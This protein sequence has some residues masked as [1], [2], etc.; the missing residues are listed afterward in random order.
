[1][2]SHLRAHLQ[3]WITD[4]TTYEQLK[5][6]VMELEALATKWDSSNSLSLPTRLGMDEAVPMEVDYIRGDKGKKGGKSKSKEKGKSKGKEKGK[7]KSEG[8]GQWKGGDKGKT[9]WEKGGS[10][11]KGKSQEKGKSGKAAG[12]CHNCGKPGHYAKDCWSSKRVAPVEGASGGASSSGGQQGTPTVTTTSSVKMVRLLTPPD[13]HSLEIFDLTEGGSGSDDIGH[14]WRVGMIRKAYESEDETEGCW[15]EFEE[16]IEP[17]VDIPEG[18]SI[19]AMDLQDETE[20]QLVQMVRMDQNDIEECL[21]TLDSG[22]ER[23]TMGA[24]HSL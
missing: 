17:V 4:T 23:G 10:G 1:M 19:V 18:V 3:L 20:E 9:L 22:A 14:P 2:P 13:S 21:V 15:S 16:C 12:V 7:W 6:K 11:K 8:K 5:N 24:W